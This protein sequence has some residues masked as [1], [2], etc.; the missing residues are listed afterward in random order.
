MLNVS[1]HLNLESQTSPADI[2]ASQRVSLGQKFVFFNYFPL[3]L[4]VRCCARNQVLWKS[5]AW[6]VQVPNGALTR[7]PVTLPSNNL[8]IPDEG[9]IFFFLFSSLI[10]CKQW[11]RPQPRGA[12]FLILIH[13]DALINNT[14]PNLLNDCKHFSCEF[15]LIR[16]SNVSLHPP[17]RGT[18]CSTRLYW[19]DS[20]RWWP[21]GAFA[22]CN[23]GVSLTH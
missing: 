16:V 1:I 15:S 7:P 6:C 17:P 4:L 20:S 13:T 12:S 11:W 23:F 18:T 9:S 22:R 19:L 10:I 3:F 2:F 5:A 14:D 21:L 8:S